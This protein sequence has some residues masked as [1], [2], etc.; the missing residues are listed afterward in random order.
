MNTSF[1]YTLRKYWHYMS[2]ASAIASSGETL[3][4]AAAERLMMRFIRPCVPFPLSPAHL[5]RSRGC[6]AK[7]RGAL[8]AYRRLPVTAHTALISIA[9]STAYSMPGASNPSTSLSQP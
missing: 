6:S 8:R 5:R 1:R 7:A 2:R 4:M 9:V 3:A